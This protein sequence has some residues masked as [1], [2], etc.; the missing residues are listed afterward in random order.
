[1]EVPKNL[2]SPSSIW[3]DIIDGAYSMLWHFLYS[4]ALG[5]VFDEIFGNRKVRAFEFFNSDSRRHRHDVICQ[6]VESRSQTV[7]SVTDHERKINVEIPH[8]SEVVDAL[9][10]MRVILKL[11]SIAVLREVIPL[12]LEVE[13]VLLGAF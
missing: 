11:D 7:D 4:G 9:P 8:I 2:S 3:L 12:I 1:M 5:S 13:Y 10:R 6:M